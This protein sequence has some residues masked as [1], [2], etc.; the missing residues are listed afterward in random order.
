MM[1]RVGVTRQTERAKSVRGESQLLQ[2]G[3]DV[4]EGGR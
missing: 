1:E 3:F 4:A 2:S